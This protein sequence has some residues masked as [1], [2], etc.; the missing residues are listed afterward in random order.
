MLKRQVNNGLLMGKENTTKKIATRKDKA[1]KPLA[2]FL[3]VLMFFVALVCNFGFLPIAESLDT[4]GAAGPPVLI[5]FMVGVFLAEPVVLG[6]W[7]IMGGGKMVLRIAGFA[8]AATLIVVAWILGLRIWSGMPNSVFWSVSG[9][10]LYAPL[11][12]LAGAMPL[13]AVRLYGANRFSRDSNEL[14]DKGGGLTIA[15]L[16]MITALVAA[17]LSLTQFTMIKQTEHPN[18]LVGN[19][20]EILFGLGMTCAFAFAVGLVVVLPSVLLMMRGGRRRF[21][22]AAIGLPVVGFGVWTV[23]FF[24]SMYSM[25]VSTPPDRIVREMWL[26]LGLAIVSCQLYLA[27]FLGTLRLG[28]WRLIGSR[29]FRP[30]TPS[31]FEPLANDELISTETKKPDAKCIGSK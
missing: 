10:V 29:D 16:M 6:I 4:R 31:R 24:V 21:W 28:G 22:Q 23:A 7:L 25:S 20:N 3:L 14:V 5:F 12:T 11:V 30:S 9:L 18:N 27:A 15:N 8:S 26:C 17:I 2:N 13:L 19:R 1:D